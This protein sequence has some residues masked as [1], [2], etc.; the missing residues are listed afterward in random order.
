MGIKANQSNNIAKVF[1]YS[2]S[3]VATS[4][5]EP[6]IMTG[7]ILTIKSIPYNEIDEED[8]IVFWSA[9]DQKY[10]V[11]R[12]IEKTDDG[13]VT[14]GDNPLVSVDEDL[15]T[16]ENY[17]GIVIKHHRFFNL[18]K[19]ILEY[20]NLVYGLIIFLFIY[21][22]VSELINITRNLKKAKI[23]EL[24]KERE[25]AKQKYYEEEKV[26]LR[27]MLEKSKNNQEFFDD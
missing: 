1:N 23:E 9:K 3:V 15:V 10:I 20:R 24:N 22:I 26:R 21:I 5:M 2:F 4:S 13:L 8:I 14:K 27:A 19:I 17:H 25:I 18:G 7:E 11:H 6:T 12:V 16:E